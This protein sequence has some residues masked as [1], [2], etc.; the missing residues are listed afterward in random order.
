MVEIMMYRNN[1]LAA[2]ACLIAASPSLADAPRLT[3]LG[4]VGFSYV[5]LD[6]PA[7]DDLNVY[8]GQASA[9][10]TFPDNWNVQADYSFA[11]YRYDGPTT[12]D[13]MKLGGSLFWRDAGEF[14][15]GAQLF[16][17]SLDTGVENDGVA[18]AA[19]VEKYW[20]D[21]TLAANIGHSSY[22]GAA[23]NIDGWQLGAKGSYYATP[24]FA[25]RVGFGYGAWDNN[26]T[27]VDTWD[28]NGEAEYLIPE[29]GTSLYAT[30]G[31]GSQNPDG[32][33][34][35]D[36]LRLGIGMR[37]HFGSEGSLRDRNRA[38]PVSGAFGTEF[39]F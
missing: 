28:L 18:I 27:D 10:W 6:G 8:R 16:Y 26:V 25:W 14:A 7:S 37:V 17:Q 21:F 5:N 31:L 24:N 30:L 2:A 11:S 20:Q 13:Q 35:T 34:E 19:F 12:I 9:L 3:G 1:L 4:D 22:D 23:L 15:A 32:T 33:N 39:T 29:Y 38:E 36:V